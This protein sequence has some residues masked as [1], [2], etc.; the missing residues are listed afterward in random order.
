MWLVFLIIL[1]GYTLFK[2][3]SD[4]N[5]DKVDLA[6]QALADKFKFTVEVLNRYVYGGE[7]TITPLD[8]RSFNLY[9]VGSNELIRFEYATGSLTITWRYKYMQ[10]EV[11]HSRTFYEV[12]NL[13]LIAQE[14]IAETVIKEMIPIKAQHQIEV[15]SEFS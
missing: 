10:K 6:H 8:L 9:K 1:I 14:R 7:A 3:L 2:F 12:R 5:E 4:L 13:S 11:V 15:L